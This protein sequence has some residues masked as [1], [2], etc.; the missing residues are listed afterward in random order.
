M[1]F[2]K[3]QALGNDY[4][5]INADD[6][7]WD[8]N[9]QRV[10]RICDP[11]FG[12]GSDGIL[13]IEKSEDPGYVASLRIFNPDGSEAE[14]SG[15]GAREAILYLRKHDWTDADTFTIM[16]ASGPVTPTITSE[17]TCAVAMGRA[18]TTSKD[19]PEGSAAGTGSLSSG[20]RDWK[21]QHVSIGNPQC[22]IEAGADLEELD[23]GRIGP[24]IENN[25][26]F[27][28]RTNVSFY[29]VSGSRVRARIF[30]RGVGETLSS[31]TGASGAAVAAFLGGTPSPITVELDGGEL[32][33][34]ITPE[35]DVTLTGWAEPIAAGRLAPEMMAA[36]AE[37]GH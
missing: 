9:P 1:E 21:F 29:R 28:N 19:Y 15:N 36:L 18:T 32:L 8:L 25:V 23:L 2:E 4:V 33:V 34:E 3:W 17:R 10:Q 6:L 35:L 14:L 26:V 16:T 13:L 12:V 7:P 27:P 31:G 30:E 22:A 24:G 5:I 20:D 37:L 11:H